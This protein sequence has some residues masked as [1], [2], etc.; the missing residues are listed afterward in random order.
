MTKYLTLTV[1]ILG[2]WIFFFKDTS[3]D[4]GPGILAPN[5]P[6]Q[7]NLSSAK[8]FTFKDH[9]ITPLAEF[10]IKAKV[11]SK[12]YYS[13]GKEAEL[14]P[15][16]LAL[17][18]GRMSDK[19]IT[20]HLN[21]SQSGR[22]YRWSTDKLPMPQ[23]EIETH[24]ANMH[25]IPKT[26]ALKEIAMS[27]AEGDIVTIKGKLVKISTKEGWHWKS[28]LSRSDRGSGACEIIFV[29]ELYIEE[30]PLP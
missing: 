11:L 21:I 2:I 18:W 14:S 20:Q 16:D 10:D 26:Q 25:L 12:E 3:V 24:S 17:G 15:L 13:H 29:E 8:S 28:S 6:V 5:D 23:R 4:Y 19:D 1:L 22:W 27:I 9:T 7:I 30:L